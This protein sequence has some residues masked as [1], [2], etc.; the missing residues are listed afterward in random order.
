[1]YFVGNFCKPLLRFITHKAL[2]LRK[3]LP[4]LWFILLFILV[5][6]KIIKHRNFFSIGNQSLANT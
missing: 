2:K 5:L 6:S 1:M 3:C 4:T